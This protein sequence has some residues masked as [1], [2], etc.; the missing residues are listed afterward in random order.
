[1]PGPNSSLRK[2]EGDDEP[3]R[4]PLEGETTRR[5]DWF[6]Q[7]GKHETEE[8]RGQGN[9]DQQDR[10]LRVRRL[11]DIAESALKAGQRGGRRKT[12]REPARD[13]QEWKDPEP[14]QNSADEAIRE[15]LPCR[16][17]HLHRPRKL[18]GLRKDA[19]S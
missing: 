12:N 19:S 18:R 7:P 10:R 13:G 9:G 16:V 8:E 11:F 17:V 6:E 2:E 3:G 1:M 15:T 14:A 4:R 5:G